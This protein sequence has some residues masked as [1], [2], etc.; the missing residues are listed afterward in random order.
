MII[1]DKIKVGG[2]IINV[3]KKPDLMVERNHL[4]EYHSKYQEI[5][6]EQS[7]TKQQMEETL[8]HEIMEAINYHYNL[9]LE[10]EKLSLIATVLHQVVKDNPELFKEGDTV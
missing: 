2:F 4:G 6:I 5:H 8:L 10:H 7:S 3:L 1:P 9:S